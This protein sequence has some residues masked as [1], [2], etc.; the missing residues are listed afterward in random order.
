[1]PEGRKV[2]VFLK[3]CPGCGKQVTVTK[4]KCGCQ[5]L[6]DPKAQ[7]GAHRGC[8]DFRK[9]GRTCYLHK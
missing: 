6:S 8:I 7:G 3:T 4:W 1:M 5:T 2:S 9:Y